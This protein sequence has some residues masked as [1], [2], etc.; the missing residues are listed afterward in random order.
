MTDCLVLSYCAIGG[1]G[2]GGGVV[3][4]EYLMYKTQ[5]S[6]TKYAVVIWPFTTCF[7]PF[8]VNAYHERTVEPN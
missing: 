7:S 4:G 3:H 1:G 2:G 6:M 5:Q 8:T